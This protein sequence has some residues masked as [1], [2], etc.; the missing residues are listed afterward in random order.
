M[1]ISQHSSGL[2]VRPSRPR[3]TWQTAAAGPIRRSTLRGRQEVLVVRN[4]MVLM[5]LMVLVRCHQLHPPSSRQRQQRLS[6][7]AVLPQFRFNSALNPQRAAQT[8]SHVATSRGLIFISC[9]ELHTLFPRRCS[10]VTRF[11]AGRH[12]AVSILRALLLILYS[13]FSPMFAASRG[14]NLGRLEELKAQPIRG[15]GWHS[16]RVTSQ[17]AGFQVWDSVPL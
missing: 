5:V 13:S 16:P 1:D 17:R 14:K 11:S 12:R 9:S 3:T 6:C 7:L 2:G 4:V 10:C 8:T 15:Q